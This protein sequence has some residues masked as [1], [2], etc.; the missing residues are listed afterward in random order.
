[1]TDLA[2]YTKRML[3]AL[4]TYWAVYEGGSG[5]DKFSWAARADGADERLWNRYER[6][7]ARVEKLIQDGAS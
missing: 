5:T 2:H 1:M 3:Q 4:D 6:Y 7:R